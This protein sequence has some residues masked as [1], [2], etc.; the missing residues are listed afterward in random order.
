MAYHE[1]MPTTQVIIQ[2]QLQSASGLPKDTFENVWHFLDATGGAVGDVAITACHKIVDF[3]TTDPGISGVGACQVMLAG[4][5][6]DTMTLIAYD[7]AAAKPRPE[8]GRVT[9]VYTPGGGDSMPE[10]VAICMSYYTDRNLVS[11]RGRLYLGPLNTVA[12]GGGDPCR[13]NTNVLKAIQ[14]GGER[15]VVIGPPVAAVATATDTIPSVGFAAGTAWALYSVKLN[16]YSAIEHGWVDD[17]WD[18]QRR[19]R[20]EASTRLTW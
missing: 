18:G 16:T 12:I 19:R 5:E 3:W 7:A 1:S 15:L 6:G 4:E 14:A 17:E 8:L 9:F 11:H 2:S 10:A 13:P 20:V